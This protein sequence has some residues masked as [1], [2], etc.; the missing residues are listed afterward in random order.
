MLH[1]FIISNIY[2]LLGARD[3]EAQLGGDDGAG[4]GVLVTS[5]DGPGG[6]HLVTSIII[7]FSVIH[8]E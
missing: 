8:R 3:D 5:E 7:M 2:Y 1:I 4:D 6:R